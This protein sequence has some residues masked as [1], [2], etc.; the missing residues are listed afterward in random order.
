[1]LNRRLKRPRFTTDRRSVAALEFALIAPLMVALLFGVYDLSEALI[2]YEE[3]YSAAHSMVASITNEAVQ[4]DGS[5]S[6]TYSEVQQGESLL[7]GEI[8]SLRADYQD[9]IKSV[10]VSSIVFEPLIPACTASNVYAAATSDDPSAQNPCANTPAGTNYIP[11]V[12][13]S[14]AY[15]G[16]D[17]GRAFQ[18]SASVLSNTQTYYPVNSQTPAS[19]SIVLAT[20]PLRSCSSST[21]TSPTSP[22]EPIYG[23]LNQSLATAGASSDLTNLRTLSLTQP[24]PSIAPP[25][26][27]LVVDVHLQY[28]PIFG[29]VIHTPL[30]FWVTSAWPVRSVKTS[31]STIYPL[32][33]EFTTINPD[34]PSGVT[35]PTKYNGNPVL[36]DNTGA[37]AP[38]SNYCVNNTM[39]NETFPFSASA[40][41][42]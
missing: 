19:T 6:L 15:A 35:N 41:S 9:G 8:P 39:P 22:P 27:I 2:I 26:P 28:M 40:I 38:I 12:V 5:N 13:W 17:S 37:L 1:M 32:Y 11:V 23:A 29:L 30:N 14:I 36:Y 18:K 42:P 31:T 33:Q 24:D 21:T 4:S 34:I 20:A 10:T 16:G 25:S 3:V 7:W